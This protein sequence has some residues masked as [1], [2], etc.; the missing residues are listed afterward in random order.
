M[1]WRPSIHRRRNRICWTIVK[2]AHIVLKCLHLARTCR[3]DILWSVNKLVL[4]R[5]ITKWTKACDKRLSRLISY[6][7]H[8][9]D[10]KQYCYVGNTAHQCKLGLFQD[11]Y[12]AGDLEDPKST[13]GGSCVFSEVTRLFQK[14]GRARNRLQ[15]HTVLQKLKSF[16]S[17]QVYAWMGFPLSIFGI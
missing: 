3:L 7:H 2:N 6:I 11:S 4:A 5:A 16:H 8:T 1:S 15:F 12:F 17:M 13:S 14:A 9:R 10:H